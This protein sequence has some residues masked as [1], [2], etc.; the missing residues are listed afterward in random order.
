MSTTQQ[1]LESLTQKWWFYLILLVLFFLP[2]Y[3][4]L[5]FDPRKTSDL[6]TAVLSK[7]LIYSIPALMPLFKL[8]PV[9][10]VLALVIWGDR[11]TRLF[12]LYAAMTI[13]LFA[14]F[15][16]MAR[17]HVFGFAVLTGNVMVYLLVSLIWFWEAGIKTNVLTFRRQSLWRYW[18]VPVAFLAFW[19]PVNPV[20]LGPEFSLAQLLNNSAGLTLCMMLPVYL[21]VLTLCYPTVNRPVLRITS[22][23][24]MITALLNVLQWFFLAFQPWMGILHLPLLTISLYGWI[25]SRKPKPGSGTANRERSSL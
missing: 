16:N 14:L 19:F 13:L 11:L 8:L 22:F 15:Q 5:P 25:L 24:G 23:A 12:D 20:S 10:L 2:S 7:P 21:A 9:L 3:S 18:V 6:I 4:S 1:R 17:T